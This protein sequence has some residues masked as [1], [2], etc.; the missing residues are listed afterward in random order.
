MRKTNIRDIVDDVVINNQQKNN[1]K[2]RE[3]KGTHNTFYADEQ[4]EWIGRQ[5]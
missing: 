3:K 4:F 5:I 1:S 2:A